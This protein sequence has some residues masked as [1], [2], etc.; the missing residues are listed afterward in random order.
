MANGFMMGSYYAAPGGWPGR[1]RAVENGSARTVWRDWG[2]GC[3]GGL[4][5]E[6]A[7]RRNA[8]YIPSRV[9]KTWECTWS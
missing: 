9:P 2:D 1:A 8:S 4:L 5:A 3:S 7:A 6:R